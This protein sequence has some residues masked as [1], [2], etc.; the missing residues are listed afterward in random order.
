MIVKF[1]CFLNCC[2]LVVTEG[3]KYIIFMA[4]QIGLLLCYYVQGLYQKN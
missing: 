3:T 1:N 2:T 4:E